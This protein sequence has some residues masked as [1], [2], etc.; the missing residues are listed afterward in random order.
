MGKK[1]VTTQIQGFKTPRRKFSL[2][3][4]GFFWKTS[5]ILLAAIFL[6]MGGSPILVSYAQNQRTEEL[7]LPMAAEIA[8]VQNPLVRATTLGQE[9]ADAQFDEARSEWFPRIQFSETFTRSNNP[10]FVFGS[11]LE[12]GHFS[13]EN[14]NIQTLNNPDPLNNFRTQVTLHQ[15]VFNQGQTLRR[16]AQARIARQQADLQKESVQQKVRFE[17]V[18]TYYG[19][20]VTQ[21]KR[22]VAQ[23]AVKMAEADVKR[24]RDR[25]ETGLTVQSDLLAA[26]VQLAE[27]R[28]QLIQTEGE[29][30]TA[31]ASLNTVLG[32][33]IDEP[34]N[35]KGELI[36]KTFD[37]PNQK[38]LI[39][40]ALV[41]RPDYLLASFAVRSNQEEV[42]GAKGQYLPDINVFANYGGS[43][44]N[45]ASGSS[46]YAFGASLIFNIFDGGRK[47]RLTQA[48]V[49]EKIASAEQEHLASQI[50]LE[51]VRAYQD[52]IS[53]RER[54][55][56]A[57]LAIARAEETFRIVQDRYQE[58]LTTIT[59]VL[60]AET[61][62]VRA[63]MSLL[64]ARYE[65]YVSYAQ[66]LLASGRLDHVEPFLS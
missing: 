20:L 29:V 61:A 6:S 53:A 12:Q 11:L 28:Q 13:Q 33:P 31:Y 45:L 58:G 5:S 1:K 39:W 3:L 51:V 54:T 59:E 15:P 7:T 34:Y 17:V 50:R 24:I 36:P 35:V 44:K 57:A 16:V 41:R 63:R 2:P 47:A 14:F 22:T 46:D 32:A 30:A 21:A 4:F 62:L 65:H 10:V 25:F 48:R 9:I 26:E 38:E 66:V 43:G 64:A 56:V 60:R 37:M 23:E 8:L 42:R 27:F 18:R 40:M 19:V 49:A 52:C 55:G